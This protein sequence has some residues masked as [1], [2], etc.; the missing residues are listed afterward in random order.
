MCKGPQG[1]V[2]VSSRSDLLVVL[3]QRSHVDSAYFPQQQ[4]LTTY[5]EYLQLGVL[6]PCLSLGVQ[7]FYWGQSHSLQPLKSSADTAWPKPFTINHIIR[8]F[9]VAHV[10]QVN[11]DS[12]AKQDIPRAQRLPPRNWGKA[13]LFFA[14]LSLYCTLWACCIFLSL[15]TAIRVILRG[16]VQDV[17][18]LISSL[19]LDLISQR[20]VGTCKSMVLRVCFMSP[21]ESLRSKLFSQ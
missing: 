3:S 8:L 17:L 21:W 14:R 7:G 6:P 13:K 19:Y 18:L 20:P 16:L 12:F 5:M 2:Q 9:V 15:E 11:R 1:R 4:C 10:P